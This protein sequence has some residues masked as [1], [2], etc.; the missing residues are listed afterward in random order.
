VPTRF[1]RFRT[2]L[3]G[4]FLHLEQHEVVEERHQILLLPGR[5]ALKR[6]PSNLGLAPVL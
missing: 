5:E 4:F 6:R 3:G 2:G 1:C